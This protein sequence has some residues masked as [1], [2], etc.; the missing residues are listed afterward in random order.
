MD[1][2]VAF[3][4]HE[5]D[6]EVNDLRHRGES[7][8]SGYK[9]EIS[10]QHD[11][12]KNLQAA[13]KA[14]EESLRRKNILIKEQDA[15]ITRLNSEPRVVSKEKNGHCKSCDELRSA[16]E[17]FQELIEKD[18]NLDSIKAM[19]V[20]KDKK[21]AET[22]KRL[23]ESERKSAGSVERLEEWKLKVTSARNETFTLKKEVRDLK[24]RIESDDDRSPVFTNEYISSCKESLQAALESV[25]EANP[26]EEN[27]VLGTMRTRTA[28]L[29]SY[30]NQLLGHCRSCSRQ[31]Q[32][33][34]IE[35]SDSEK[36]T[37]S[38]VISG[39]ICSDC[40]GLKERYAALCNVN[41][42]L[43]EAL[44]KYEDMTLM[45]KVTTQHQLLWGPSF[46]RVMKMISNLNMP[47]CTDSFARNW[48]AM[49]V[50]QLERLK[51]KVEERAAHGRDRSRT[52]SSAT[53]SSSRTNKRKRRLSDSTDAAT[54]SEA[55][56]V[57]KKGKTALLTSEV[58]TSHMPDNVSLSR[59]ATPALRA[60]TPV[61]RSQTPQSRPGTVAPSIVSVKSEPVH[62]SDASQ[63]D[64]PADVPRGE[65]SSASNPG[66]Q[67]ETP[68]DSH[69]NNNPYRIQPEVLKRIQAEA[70]RIVE[71]V[72]AADASNSLTSAA[73][74]SF[75]QGLMQWLEKESAGILEQ[76]VLTSAQAEA[77]GIRRAPQVSSRHSRTSSFTQDS[78]GDSDLTAHIQEV[79]ARVTG[80]SSPQSQ[81][82]FISAEGQGQPVAMESKRGDPGG[83]GESSLNFIR[84]ENML[85]T[86]YIML[87]DERNKVQS[88]G[89]K[90][91][92][93]N[94]EIKDL[95]QRWERLQALRGNSPSSE[96][97]TTTS[98]QTL[99]PARRP[100]QTTPVDKQTT[101]V[102]GNERITMSIVSPLPAPS[103]EQLT[104]RLNITN[105]FFC[106]TPRVHQSVPQHP[107]PS[108]LLNTT[109]SQPQTPPSV[110]N[111][112]QAVTPTS[113]VTPISQTQNNIHPS[114][115]HLGGQ[116][117]PMMPQATPPILS[118][119]S[120]HVQYLNSLVTQQH[121]NRQVQP[122]PHIDVPTQ[123]QQ[124]FFPNPTEQ[125]ETNPSRRTWQNLSGCGTQGQGQ[126]SRG[127]EA[128]SSNPSAVTR[129]SSH[130]QRNFSVNQAG[131]SQGQVQGFGQGHGQVQHSQGQV[132]RGVEASSSN[133]SAVTRVSS[134]EQRNFSVN[135]AGRSQGQV[136]GCGQGHGQVQHSQGQVSR[137]VEASSSNPSAVTRVSSHEQWNF[138]VNQAGRSQGQVQGFG[139]GHGQVQHSQVQGH[140]QVQGQHQ[141]VDQRGAV[142]W[143]PNEYR[144][145]QPGQLLTARPQFWLPP[146]PPQTPSTVRQYQNTFNVMRK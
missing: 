10:R 93:L 145:S 14:K 105:N 8:L 98:E 56:A 35:E 69:Q 67:E 40:K 102:S 46:S 13:V 109:E 37:K 64:A 97:L 90:M 135:Q 113:V 60:H 65:T 15:E 16:L 121:G 130:E 123:P 104:K 92:R 7:I 73:N 80:T 112:L 20:E 84:V 83:Q 2:E 38:K 88:Q 136:Q 45:L 52:D 101:P 118:H 43:V 50:P 27:D 115:P 74:V 125:L 71:K 44:V 128:S 89:P 117:M 3:K 5:S 48:Q 139:Q 33:S 12:I 42:R 129:V 106:G 143:V 51:V 144:T 62:Q 1:T 49:I 94:M 41:D 26:D 127:V 99:A 141:H 24:R 25:A 91:D 32:D 66:R 140:G 29:C 30:F 72:E 55:E 28:A 137:V 57:Q 53:E 34:G 138:S 103:V 54:A 95:L 63:I 107:H 86:K 119:L 114:M 11:E 108:T 77:T 39:K 100:R 75:T 31:D 18:F 126:G 68:S 19:L 79:F 120:S 116:Q 124:R 47:P 134:H 82:Q 110:E 6:L 70:P 76:A 21:L 9:T 133:P 131:R 59:P 81:G 4:I 22:E 17:E 122:L 85:V 61:S 58:E 146:P 96:Q 111:V 36:K 132:S 23:A 142:H 87:M 78:P